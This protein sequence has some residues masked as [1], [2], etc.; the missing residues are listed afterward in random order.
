MLYVLYWELNE[1]MPV[2]ERLKIAQKLTSSGLF[3]P[4]GVKVIRWDMT[5]D[6]WGI[7]IIEADNSWDVFSTVSMWR[8]ASPGFF[9]MTKLAPAMPVQEVMPREGELLKK[10]AST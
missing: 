9:R 8:S 3:P 7:S 2:E 6:L 5:P 1:N 10:L 4:K